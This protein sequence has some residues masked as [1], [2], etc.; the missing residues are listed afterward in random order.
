MPDDKP[1]KQN[2]WLQAGRISQIAFVLPAATVVGWGLG[3]ALDHWLHT[4]WLQIAGLIV[5][6]VAGFVDLIKTAIANSK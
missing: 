3:L 6:I 5:G 4:N 2:F 1:S